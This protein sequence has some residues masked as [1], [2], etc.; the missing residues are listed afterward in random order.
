MKHRYEGLLILNI[1]GTEE[2]AKE[3]VDRLEGEFKSE[4]AEIEQVQKLERRNFTYAAGPLSSG[5]YVNF[6]FHSEPTA[7]DRLKAKFR[8][9]SDVYRQ[10][11]LKV[12]P[13]KFVTPRMPKPE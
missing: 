13:K 1:T 12:G 2:S 6:I 9:D 3:I 10:Q 5:Y 11:Y 7:I 8:L 4:G